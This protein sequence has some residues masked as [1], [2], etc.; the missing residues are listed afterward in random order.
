MAMSLDETFVLSPPTV[1]KCLEE[2]SSSSSHITPCQ[3]YLRGHR[4][5]STPLFTK[6]CF[7]I[8]VPYFLGTCTWVLN[9]NGPCRTFQKFSGS[10]QCWGPA[11][12]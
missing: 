12:F 8:P 10:G 4:W 1:V 5:A 3:Y 2:G 9:S 11:C 6:V 7:Y